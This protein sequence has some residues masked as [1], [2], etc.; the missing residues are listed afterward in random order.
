MCAWK[1][2]LLFPGPPTRSMHDGSALMP[3]PYYFKDMTTRQ[4]IAWA[5]GIVLIP[6]VF[7]LGIAGMGILLD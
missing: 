2:P 3:L 5:L 4:K 7:L 1:F 6:V